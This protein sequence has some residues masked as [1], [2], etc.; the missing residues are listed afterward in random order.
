MRFLWLTAPFVLAAS[1]ALAASETPKPKP[2]AGKQVEEV[3]VTG[4]SRQ[5]LRTEVDRRSYGISGDLQTTTGSIG[6]ALRNVPSLSVDVQGNVALRGDSN[7]TI[8]VDGQPSGQ[9]RGEGRAAALQNLPAD[10]FERVEVI[11]TP[12]AEFRPDGAGIINL[13]SKKARKP[14]YSGSLRA[15]Y[16]SEGRDTAGV[17]GSYNSGKLTLSGDASL[18][19]DPQKFQTVETRSG[20]NPAAG[21]TD[22]RN[23]AQFRGHGRIVTGRL[24]ADYDLDPKTRVSAEVRGN[25]MAIRNGQFEQEVGRDGSGAVTRLYDRV[26]RLNF[27]RSNEAATASYRRKFASDN[28]LT[29]SLRLERTEVENRNSAGLIT[30]LPTAGVSHEFLP[31]DAREDELALKADY[32]RPFADGGK[33]KAGVELG[34]LDYDFDFSALRGADP[35]ALAVVPALDN[36]FRYDLVSPSGYVTVERPFGKLTA[37]AGL[38]LQSVD[39]DLVQ[40][41]TGETGGQN[42][43]NAYPSLHLGYRLSDEQQL[44][45]AYSRRITRSNPDELNPL[46]IYIDASNIRVGNPDLK[47]VRIDAFEAAWQLRKGSTYY[48][49]TVFYRASQD[50]PSDVFTDLGGGVLLRSRENLGERKAGGLELVA[51]G[52]ITPK[53]TYNVSGNVAWNQID[54]GNLGFAGKRSDVALSGRG[55]LNWQ[56]TPK[57]FLQASGN[58]VGDQLTPQGRVEA[59]GFLNLGYRHKFTDDLSL[60]VTAQDVLKTSPFVIVVDTPDLRVRR[61]S[62][63][64][65]QAVFIGFTWAFGGQG[66]RPKDPGFDFGGGP[67]GS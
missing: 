4:Q 51:N 55:T 39:I 23:L 22:S 17:S 18:R 63:A 28:D 66:K 11:T 12:S 42:R 41:T 54:A 9:F 56:V 21:V 60:V 36:S 65:I 62:E 34:L 8:M 38:R 13:I 52:K 24:A 47:P 31:L 48:L 46:R 40:R 44:T 61:R 53:L 14:G 16:G 35:R 67:P 6:D 29:V 5:G 3:T 59:F 37:L 33:L 58:V 19:R 49:A 15:T 32:V 26:G 27:A 25:R 64:N 2:E 10:Q 20:L 50:V 1:S 43:L 7:V 57:D 30:R 45:L